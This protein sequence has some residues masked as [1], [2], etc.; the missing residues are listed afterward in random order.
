MAKG[1]WLFFCCF[2]VG[3]IILHY[4]MDS[5]NTFS[6]CDHSGAPYERRGTSS[7]LSETG[8]RISENV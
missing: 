2:T 3:V 6:V 7:C 1:Q 4:N 5:I 8:T